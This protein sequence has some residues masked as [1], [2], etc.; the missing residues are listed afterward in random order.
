M[1][2]WNRTRAVRVVLTLL[3]AIPLIA[4]STSP[5]ATLPV[6]PVSANDLGDRISVGRERQQELL[7]AIEQQRDLLKDLRADEGLAGRALDSSAEA[8][9]GIN[10]DQTVLREDIEQAAR[11]LARVEA[12]RDDL[13]LELDTLDETIE[14]LEAD[15]AQ[16]ERDLADRR[17]LL[18]ERLVVAYRTSQTSLLEQILGSS[19]FSDVLIGVDAHL[20]FG[21]Q[22]AQFARLIQEDQAALDSLRQSTLETRF[23]TDKL[24]LETVAA[25]EALQ[26]EQ[27]RLAR[28]RGRLAAMEE[29]T[30]RLRTAQQD[31][32]QRIVGDQ[33]DAQA[34]IARKQAAEDAL[35]VEIAGLVAEAQRRAEARERRLEL[36]RQRRIEER[37]QRRE[38]LERAQR[39]R[40]ARQQREAGGQRDEPQE[41]AEPPRARPEPAPTPPRPSGPL[42]WPTVGY[43]TQEFGCTGFYLEPRRGSCAHFHD[44]IDIANGEGTAIRAAAAG[45]V[46]FV[47]Y[48]PYD[49]GRDRA[50]VVSLGHAGSLVSWYSHLQPRY[51]PGVRGGS[52]VRQGQVIG[53]MG[54]TGNSTGAHLHWEVLVDG[55]VVDPRSLL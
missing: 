20:R 51:A 32:F 53:Y 25:G 34:D 3:L 27:E 42:D 36:E 29:R 37:E 54:N 55:S 30:R 2:A 39:R 46:A 21:E 13:A 26:V 10:A 19:S 18:G 47:G 48:N 14:Q 8:L 43:V 45:V 38:E 16:G 6:V 35:R 31:E 17:R 5:L 11:T 40:E 9:D 41:P 50:W 52:R 12:L 49:S 7:G 22:D 33:G 23:E 1:S 4:P 44:G 24:R 28:A 15:I